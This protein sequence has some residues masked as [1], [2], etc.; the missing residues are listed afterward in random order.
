MSRTNSHNDS[1][2]SKYRAN[3]YSSNNQPK[4]SNLWISDKCIELKKKLRSANP[5]SF[6]VV[7]KIYPND[8]NKSIDGISNGAKK[9]NEGN[10]FNRRNNK[11][12]NFNDSKIK[13]I[14]T[15]IEN[16]KQDI[17]NIEEKYLLSQNSAYKCKAGS[18]NRTSSGFDQKTKGVSPNLSKYSPKKKES[19]RYE[20]RNQANASSIAKVIP[21]SALEEKLNPTFTRNKSSKHKPRARNEVSL[22]GN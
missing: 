16:K 15:K 5:N 19:D 21:A 14:L 12:N 20:S 2:Q 8:S 10:F 3:Y 18:H 9:V 1:A 13:D 6:K 4:K 22:Q 11:F 17:K 7:H